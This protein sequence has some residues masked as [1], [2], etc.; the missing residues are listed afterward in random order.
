MTEKTAEQAIT[1]EPPRAQMV[2]YIKTAIG[3]GYQPEHEAAVTNLNVIDNLGDSAINREFGKCWQWYNMGGGWHET[4]TKAAEEIKSDAMAT[5][6]EY[7][8]NGGRDWESVSELFDAI[9]DGK[10]PHV[11]ISK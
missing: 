10:I 9:R 1:L 6:Q 3:E 5:M 2:E 11:E 8:P 7:F 4:F